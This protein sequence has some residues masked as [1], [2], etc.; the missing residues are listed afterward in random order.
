MQMTWQMG[1]HRINR[2]GWIKQDHE[3]KEDTKY[4]SKQ[5]TD[6]IQDYILKDQ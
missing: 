3:D 2:T 6:G 1:L 4:T 5:N